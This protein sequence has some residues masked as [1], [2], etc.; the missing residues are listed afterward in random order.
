MV[1][2]GNKDVTAIS[3][4]GYAE[5]TL[6]EMFGC[7]YSICWL[8]NYPC[9]FSVKDRTVNDF[10]LS[11]SSSN[12]EPSSSEDIIGLAYCHNL[13][14]LKFRFHHISKEANDFILL[15]EGSS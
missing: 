7:R 1:Q 13:F 15:P 14:F 4:N 5:C 2:F 12:V 3:L 9:E 6:S 11:L 10:V 8:W